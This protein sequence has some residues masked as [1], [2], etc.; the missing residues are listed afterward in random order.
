[1]QHSCQIAIEQPSLVITWHGLQ[2]FLIGTSEKPVASDCRIG[3]ALVW[4]WIANTFERL[5]PLLVTFWAVFWCPKFIYYKD[6]EALVSYILL[7][8]I[9]RIG[10]WYFV[11]PQLQFPRTSMA[12][13]P[14]LLRKL[15]A[16]RESACFNS[17]MPISEAFEKGSPRYWDGWTSFLH[18][19]ALVQG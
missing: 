7:I 18:R 9:P 6:L 15:A 19:E 10:S 13:S 2:T 11:L 12:S 17:C 4:P 14:N 8:S 5:K 16:S 3:L 1:M